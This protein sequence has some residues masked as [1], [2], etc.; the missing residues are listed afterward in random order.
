MT[1]SAHFTPT[2]SFHAID[3]TYSTL[4]GLIDVYFPFYG[5]KEKDFF[6]LFPILVYAEATIY[7]ID[8]E[9][10]AN[11]YQQDFVSP[12]W[13]HLETIL[14]EKNLLDSQIEQEFKNALTY[15]ALERKMCSG[16]PFTLEELKL[17]HRHK[18]YD[19]RVLHRLLYRLRNKPYDEAVIMAFTMGEMMADVEEDLRQYEDEVKKNSFNVYRMFVKLYKQDAP[20]KIKEYLDEL[21]VKVYAAI[22]QASWLQR[23]KFKLSLKLYR[24]ICPLPKI[25]QPILTDCQ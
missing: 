21:T 24:A 25:P 11:I 6:P 8:E 10:E 1:S 9:N 15:Y 14:R 7:Q 13:Q 18:A 3:K 16:K 4:K 19:Y 20:Q 23:S 5:L 2:V 22:N 17:A 12:H